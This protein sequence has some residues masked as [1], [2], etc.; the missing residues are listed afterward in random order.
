MAVY[1]I[2]WQAA[3]PASCRDGAV[4]VGN[5]DGVHLGHAALLSKLKDASK[6][7][8]GPAVA[9][10]FEPHPVCL[11]RPDL[12]PPALTT[13]TDRTERLRAGGAD[14]VLMLQ[15]DLDMLHLSAEDFFERM[16]RAKLAPRILVEGV[17]FGFGRNR[18]GNIETLAQLCSQAGIGLQSLPPLLV[19]G[20]AVSSSRV[21]GA[22]LR[23]AVADA[24][25]LLGRPYRLRGHVRAGQQRGQIIGFPTANIERMETLIPGDGVYAVRAEHR[26]KV[27][28]G[29]ANLGS[30]PTF[31]EAERKVEVH[32]ID[33]QGDL[34][35]ETL[36]IDFLDRMRDTRPFA[37]TAELAAQLRLDVEQA[38]HVA[39]SIK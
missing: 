13:A 35:G 28:P 39:A 31:G 5:F 7:V 29:A 32:L 10:T 38:R 27:W 6:G 19:D 37:G 18:E 14:H 12:C 1:E 30:N 8:K 21:R 23:G 33:F 24:A 2:P 34:Y 26:G 16:I 36:A 3:F 25:R 15:I 20:H 4:T 17:N 9:L 11:L 22:L